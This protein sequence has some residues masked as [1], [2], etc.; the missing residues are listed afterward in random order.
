MPPPEPVPSPPARASS[1]TPPKPAPVTLQWESLLER[2]ESAHP[3]LAPFLAQGTLLS[4][5]G[6]QVNIGFPKTASVALSR[7]QNEGSLRQLTA[8][9]AELARQPVRVRMVELAEGQSAGPSMAQIRAAKERDQKQA[10]LEGTR[11][12]PLVKQA[13]EVFGGDLVEVRRVPSR[14]ETPS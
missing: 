6:T 4:I 2:V 12:H 1:D 3:S 13:L 11:S 8:L 7:M 14:K 5:E 10:L 9:C